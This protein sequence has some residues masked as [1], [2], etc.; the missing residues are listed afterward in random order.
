MAGRA[1]AK[2]RSS[3]LSCRGSS[4][5]A[6]SSRGLRFA[7]EFPIRLCAMLRVPGRAHPA[8]SGRHGPRAGSVR[9]TPLVHLPKKRLSGGVRVALRA[10]Q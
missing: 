4:V 3:R 8:D 9:V 7:P 1:P 5:E 2:V 6:A 10:Q